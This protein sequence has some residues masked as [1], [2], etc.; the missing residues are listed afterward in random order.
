M[1]K[2]II[3]L[4]IVLAALVGIAQS[5]ADDQKQELSTYLD[6]QITIMENAVVSGG[7]ENPTVAPQSEQPYYFFRRFWLRVRAKATFDLPGLFKLQIAPEA[8]MLWER[9]IPAG[10]TSY[11]PAQQAALN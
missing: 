6:Q 5:S 7:I 2:G 9:P 1:R 11:K 8:E 3:A 4:T 10:W